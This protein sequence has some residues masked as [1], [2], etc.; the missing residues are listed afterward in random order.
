MS[1]YDDHEN[2]ERATESAPA[3]HNAATYL[4]GMDAH[5][6]PLAGL[7]GDDPLATVDDALVSESVP[8]GPQPLGLLR[9][10]I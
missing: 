6:F 9:M 10:P 4:L 2:Q 5:E 8:R 7:P 1:Y 3:A